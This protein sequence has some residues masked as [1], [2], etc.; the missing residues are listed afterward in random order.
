M[1]STTYTQA[2]SNINGRLVQLYL[3]STPIGHFIVVAWEMPGKEVQRKIFDE[4]YDAA[5]RYYKKICQKIVAET[6]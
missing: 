2:E 1:N 5:A 6:I 4:D 3:I